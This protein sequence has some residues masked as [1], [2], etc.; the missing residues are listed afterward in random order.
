VFDEK[1][2]DPLFDKVRER[3]KFTQTNFRVGN[4]RPS[5][6]SSYNRQFVNLHNDSDVKYVTKDD[7]N[8][9][10]ASHWD[11]SRS[12]SQNFRTEQKQRFLGKWNGKNYADNK[13]F[14][15]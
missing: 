5:H 13:H 14:G 15:Y 7:K 6:L 8:Q 12:Y 11:H 3:E 2:V 4:L 1:E 10:E 9:L